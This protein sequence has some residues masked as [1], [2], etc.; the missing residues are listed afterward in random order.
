MSAET[1]SP[2][3][4]P[5]HGLDRDTD[6][7]SCPVYPYEPNKGAPVVLAVLFAATMVWHL[8]Q[9]HRYKCWKMTLP[10]PW[11]ALLFVAGFCIREANA[12]HDANLNLFITEQVLL[13]VAP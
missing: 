13:V 8:I 9:I 7:Y 2:S 10:L 4:S 3:A 1:V 6:R 11:G 5:Y 12:Y